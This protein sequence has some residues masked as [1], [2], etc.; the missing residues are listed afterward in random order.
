MS[1][2]TTQA[3]ARVSKIAGRRADRLEHGGGWPVLTRLYQRLGSRILLV[4]MASNVVIILVTGAVSILLGA[5]YL[6]LSTS[7][8]ATT[9]AIWA[10]IFVGLAFAALIPSI[11]LVR[12]VLG[13]SGAGRTAAR[14]P[15]VW[16]AIVTGERTAGRC[17]AL[18]MVAIPPF[19]VYIVSEFDKPWYGVFP[20]MIG[21]IVVGVGLWAVVVLVGQ[22][23]L[24]PLWQD[25]ASF[26]PTDFEPQMRGIRLRSKALAPL[27][28]VAFYAAVIA[29]AY[30]N[31]SVNGTLRF[32]IALVA[33]LGIA[34]VAA[35][36][37]AIVTR[38][39]LSP[40]DDLLAATRRVAT[41]DLKTPVPVVT[42]DELGELAQSFNQMLTDLSAHTEALSQS[43]AE[44]RQQAQELRASRERIVTAADAERRKVERDLHDGAQQHL[45]LLNLKLAMAQRLIDTDPAGAKAMHDE[46]RADLERALAELRDLAHGIYPQA[47][48]SEGLPAALREAAQRSAIPTTIEADGTTRYR[49]ELEAAVYFCCLEAFQ[50][51]GK[52]AGEGAT[53]IIRL[54]DRDGSM[55]FEIVDTGAGF[56]PSAIRESAGIQNMTD[57]IGALGGE[58]TI[59][60]TPG[61]GTT[62]AGTVPLAD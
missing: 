29:G 62:I 13:W 23:I 21:L 52:H 61:H 31:V 60:S 12:T 47:L 17:A 53:A 28:V 24:R 4:W 19:A 14:A 27:P 54:A 50:N 48:E 45:V 25:V 40:I 34:L 49:P 20:V 8:A 39:A 37:F 58:L 38:S 41:G 55:H 33:A 56:D 6:S 16:N 42:A 32:T 36:I 3:R 26:L 59:T 22:T 46:V 51:A 57:R 2:E 11:G 1:I 35:G 5:R 9:F 10:P 7:Q 18:A 15:A 43:R 30:A 44:L